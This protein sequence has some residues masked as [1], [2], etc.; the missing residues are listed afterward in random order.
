MATGVGYAMRQRLPG[1]EVLTVQPE[2]APGMTLSLRSGHAV[3]AGPP[4]TIADGVAG[5]YVLPEVLDDLREVV[6]E[7]FLVSEESIRDAMRLL[8][9]CSGLIVEPA[10]AL[11]VA[12]ILENR[13]RFRGMTVATIL[14]GGNISTTDFEKLVAQNS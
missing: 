11:G 10:A 9:R 8:Y 14:C 1:I 3:D 2:Q 7:A 6:T 13:D 5:R 4:A 12:T